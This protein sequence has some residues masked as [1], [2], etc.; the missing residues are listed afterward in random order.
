[1]PAGMED[2]AKGSPKKRPHDQDNG[3]ALDGSSARVDPDARCLHGVYTC[4][5]YLSSPFGNRGLLPCLPA[6]NLMRKVDLWLRRVGVEEKATSSRSTCSSV[7][8]V[9]C[10]PGTV[11]SDSSNGFLQVEVGKD[12]SRARNNPFRSVLLLRALFDRKLVEYYLDSLILQRV[13][14]SM[15]SSRLSHRTGRHPRCKGLS[16]TIAFGMWTISRWM[17]VNETKL[18]SFFSPWTVT[19]ARFLTWPGRLA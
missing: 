8:L 2:E 19:N 18:S 7:H 16:S 5:T 17:K 12:Q 10:C 9:W 14:I 15:E 13:G 4:F 6:A 1:M 11:T 3:H